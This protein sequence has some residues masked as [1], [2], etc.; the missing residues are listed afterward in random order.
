MTRSIRPLRRAAVVASLCLAVGV[1]GTVVPAA[2]DGTFTLT[3][4]TAGNE[5]GR[6]HV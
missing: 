4:A 6:A 5:I 1:A 3:A 2:A